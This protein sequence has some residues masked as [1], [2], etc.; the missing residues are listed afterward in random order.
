M[1]LVRVHGPLKRLIADG[2]VQRLEASNINA[3]L[4]E[5]ERSNPQAAGWLLDER[6]RLRR[7]IN[8]FV[9][10]ERSAPDDAISPED[11]VE[12]LPAISGG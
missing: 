1:A 3:L 4:R 12:V 7:H 5:I 11:R 2:G 8:I 6:G 9:N 10:G